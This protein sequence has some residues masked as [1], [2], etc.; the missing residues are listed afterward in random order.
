MVHHP[1]LGLTSV[2]AA[3]VPTVDF[4]PVVHQ[5]YAERVLP[6]KDG[7]PEL[8]GIPARVDGSGKVVPE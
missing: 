4:K 8:T 7:L 1:S 2:F 6:I 3:V 5:N